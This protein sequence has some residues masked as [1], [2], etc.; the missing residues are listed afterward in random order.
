MTDKIKFKRKI[1]VFLNKNYKPSLNKRRIKNF[2]K[3]PRQIKATIG[4]ISIM[5]I[6]GISA[7]KGA[8]KMSLNFL[9]VLNGSLYHFMFGIQVK[10]IEINKSK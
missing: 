3:T 10:R 8:K 2:L 1:F 6:G 9:K 7:L 5:P 4:E